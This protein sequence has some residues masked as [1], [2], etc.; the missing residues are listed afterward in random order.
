MPWSEVVF[1]TVRRYLCPTHPLDKMPLSLSL[2]NTMTVVVFNQF[3][4]VHW[5]DI[6][7]ITNFANT[8]AP[9]NRDMSGGL[10]GRRHFVFIAVTVT[11]YPDQNISTFSF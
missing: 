6:T 9:E 2:G 3:Y 10:P 7:V 1:L 4:A 11:E 5:G 8:Q